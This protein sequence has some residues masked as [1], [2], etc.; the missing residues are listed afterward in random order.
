MVLE[1]ALSPSRFDLPLGIS[2][3]THA[4]EAYCGRPLI[5]RETH[6]GGIV[7]V[8]YQTVPPHSALPN[9]RRCLPSR[10]CVP[11]LISFAPCPAVRRPSHLQIGLA[12]RAAAVGG[13]QDAGPR[14]GGALL[15]GH[16]GGDVCVRVRRAAA[17]RR[18]SGENA[19]RQPTPS[20]SIFEPNVEADV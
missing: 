1:A 12:R 6:P 15:G 18:G 11:L 17:H 4:K 9:H 19:A 3:P 2:Q 8:S 14:L 10:R 5:L 13:V 16:S 20:P 7:E